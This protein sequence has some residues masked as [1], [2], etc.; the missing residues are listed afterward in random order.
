[1]DVGAAHEIL[2]TKFD[3][4]TGTDTPVQTIGNDAV[5][6]VESEGR[7]L[8]ITLPALCADSAT[9]LRLL[10]DL[11]AAYQARLNGWRYQAAPSQYTDYAA[12]KNKAG[13]DAPDWASGAAP[14]ATGLGQTAAA[15]PRSFTPARVMRRLED[16]LAAKVDELAKAHDA[17]V[18]EV[19]LACW[20]LMLARLMPRNDITVFQSVAAKHDA[21][22]QEAL[23]PF[24]EW[25]AVTIPVSD[26][27]TL[28]DVISRLRAADV[29]GAVA[30]SPARVGFS[31]AEAPANDSFRIIDAFAY[32]DQFVVKLA[33]LLTGSDISV[34][35]EFDSAC[36]SRKAA[37]ILLER[38]E[39]VLRDG[40]WAGVGAAER[41]TILE[42]STG[43]AME[44]QL[45]KPVHRFFEEQA[46]IYPQKTAVRCGDQS[47]SYAALNAGANDLARRLQARGVGPE[48][49]VAIYAPRSVAMAAGILGVLKAGG[50]FVPLDPSYP[51][52]RI[53]KLLDD[54]RPL[55]TLTT[56]ELLDAIPAGSGEVMLLDFESGQDAGD[57]DYASPSSL[58]Y[59]MYTSGSTGQPKGV[60]ITH[61][62]LC[63][64]VQSLGAELGITVDDSYLHTAS[65]AFSS[66]VRQLLL[67]LSVG[68]TVEIAARERIEDPVAL[69]ELVKSQQVSI[70]D[71]V[72]TYWRHCTSSLSA[73]PER[74][75]EELLK[76]DLRLIL[77]ASEALLSDV[78]AVWARQFRHPARLINMLGHTEASGIVATFPIMCDQDEAV[79][80]V[81]VG[82]P[83]PNTQIFLLDEKGDLAPLGVP[84]EIYLGGPAL[85]R[86]YWKSND[87]TSERFMKHDLAGSSVLHRTGDLGLRGFDGTLQFLGRMDSQV[88][89]RGIRIQPQEIESALLEHPGVRNA[90]VSVRERDGEQQLIAYVTLRDRYAATVAGLRRYSLP[91]GMRIAHLNEYET[92]F[93]Y[94]QIFVDQTNFLHGLELQAGDVVIDVGANIGLF[95][96]FAA[97]AAKD[98]TVYAFEPVPSV[99]QALEA[100][101]SW[102]GKGNIRAFACGLSSSPGQ[103]SITYYPHST[104]QST[105]FSDQKE[106]QETLRAV[107]ANAERPLSESEVDGIVAERMQSETVPCEIK[108][109]SQI[110]AEHQLTRVDLLKIDV[111]KS[112]FEVLKGIREEDW[113]KIQQIVI[114]AHDVNGQLERLTSLIQGAGYQVTVEQDHSIAGS[115]LYNVYATRRKRGPS[116][117][118]SAV[119][120]PIPE[121]QDPVLDS[122][123]LRRH[124]ETKLPA[125]YMPSRILLVDT[126]PLTPNGKVDR[127]ALPEPPEDQRAEASVEEL[128]STPLEELLA[129]IWREVLKTPTVRRH[130]NF[131]E[132]GGHSLA[133][134]QLVSRIRGL[135]GVEMSLRM[136]FQSPTIAEL[137]PAILEKQLEQQADDLGVILSELQ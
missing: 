42:L 109:L 59:V 10:A 52:E 60:M 22:L 97:H 118:G 46:R 125:A 37:E 131:F 5:L 110:I 89:I 30:A 50:A 4:L 80:G 24:E 129:E 82:R 121:C 62:N 90:A 108:T 115:R 25:R 67:P 136:L 48:V 103:A 71:L 16:S 116:R 84:G 120:Y 69:F 68:A 83:I 6:K 107:L 1:M 14:L 95:S 130:D 47:L 26:D 40:R 32:T 28:A 91:N 105:L 75:R 20:Y 11:A 78:P 27:T 8:V 43:A 55:V 122:G 56:P 65:F 135:C 79:K 74:R 106:D 137:A 36:V 3:V 77:S 64:Y 73:L 86:G 35:V 117:D 126:I 94:D 12:W 17:L 132:I 31:C 39:S 98:V 113:C 13:G 54:A 7:E 41:E 63:H 58:A 123:E 92:K 21:A 53:E 134:M 51:K 23:G 76:N 93:F 72:P 33:C 18:S 49:L 96:V 87:L 104:V 102:Y 38:F 112:E 88:K 85:S 100:N 44:A 15:D 119:R 81:P 127:R 99:F 111:E 128:L 133:A 124:L 61:A 114:E 34:G 9:L 66:S 2:R 19:L 70:I 29:G 101:A 57:P 45:G